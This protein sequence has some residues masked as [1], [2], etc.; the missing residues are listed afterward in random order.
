VKAGAVELA[1]AY[2]DYGLGAHDFEQRFTRL[3]RLAGLRA[4][5]TVSAELRT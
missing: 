3:A 4:A 5:G 1:E 2:R